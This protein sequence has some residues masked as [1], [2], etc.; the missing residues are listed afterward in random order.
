MRDAARPDKTCRHATRLRPDDT[1]VC[2][3]QPHSRCRQA[4]FFGIRRANSD[5]MMRGLLVCLALASAAV[6]APASTPLGRDYSQ[7]GPYGLGPAYIAADST[8][9]LYTMMPCPPN[10]TSTYCV[11][12]LS[13]DGATILW[14]NNLGFA[15]AMAVDPTGG[16]Y[17]AGD[18]NA[19][20]SSLV[21]VEKLS[22]DGSS[23]AW[24]TVLNGTQANGAAGGPPGEPPR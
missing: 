12:K 18:P 4:A 9:A 15:G 21:V 7:Y 13:A 2:R 22:A 3:S 1:S 23:V 16:V 5:G 14:Q 8:G 17:V 6:A 11:T 20:Y 10:V 19:Q 24:Q